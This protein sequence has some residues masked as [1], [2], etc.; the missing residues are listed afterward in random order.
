M[1]GINDTLTLT[2]TNAI[3]KNG[4][5]LDYVYSFP[6]ANEEL[7]VSDDIR[8]IDIIE[9]QG[10]LNYHMQSFT[11]Y[12]G[13]LTN[14]EHA[15]CNN[16]VFESGIIDKFNSKCQDATQN[17][18]CYHKIDGKNIAYAIVN[19]DDIVVE[20][21]VKFKNILLN[22]SFK[23]RTVKNSV[24]NVKTYKYSKTVTPRY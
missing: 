21:I 17:V 5:T 14:M 2:A 11:I 7:K 9:C 13:K 18:V 10:D 8:Q 16:F 4:K 19:N 1:F 12:I 24:E 15:I 20:D 3:N 6:F 22:L 23:F